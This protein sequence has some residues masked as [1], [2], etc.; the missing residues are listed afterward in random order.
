MKTNLNHIIALQNFIQSKFNKDVLYHKL[1]GVILPFVKEHH[2][3]LVAV[4]VP[5]LKNFSKYTKIPRKDQLVDIVI[6]PFY[7]EAAFALF[8]EKA[9]TG[10][11]TLM[12][13]LVWTREAF[14]QDDIEADLGL[15]IYDEK[16]ETR[17][18][19]TVYKS[20]SIQ[21][22]FG[23]FT[24]T[25]ASYYYYHQQSNGY[26]VG[27]PDSLKRVISQ[28][29]EKPKAAYLTGF[30]E[31]KD[32]TLLRYTTGEMDIHL[33]FPRILAYHKQG[34]IKFSAKGKPAVSTLNKMQ[35]TLKL[36]PFYPKETDKKLTVLRTRLIAGI[37]GVGSNLKIA[38]PVHETIKLYFSDYYLKRYESSQ[39]LLNHLSGVGYLD[40]YYTEDIEP[41]FIQILENLPIGKWVSIDNVEGYIMYNF[42][43][44]EIVSRNTAADKL[45]YSN[46]VGRYTEKD[47]IDD[48][49][50]D[51]AIVKPS[52]NGTMFL[53]GAFGLLDLMYYT[54]D[55]DFLGESA[56]SDYDD[57]KYV[58]LTPLG[59]YVVGRNK[60]YKPS[61][62]ASDSQI[63]LSKDSLTITT[64][65][66]NT[67]A[68]VILSPYAER[69]TPNRYR[70][71]Y[72][73]FLKNCS[74]KKELENKINL[75]KQTVCNKPPQNWLDFFTELNNKIN[76][77]K[78][79]T[80]ITTFQIP[81]ENQT[82]VKII[83]KDNKLKN[84][85]IKAEG[86]MVL[87]KKSNMPAFKKRLKEFGYLV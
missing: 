49:F 17:W 38:L 21:S 16:E 70:T 36:K 19:N 4:G 73:F 65:K 87:V 42:L 32:E 44:V 3:D 64:D 80:N 79:V 13:N 72:T 2:D 78:K 26:F 56:F 66:N 9:P 24:I 18:N 61:E 1:K 10:F 54:P 29:Y 34:N 40:D 52:I 58:R 59:A 5:R 43:P 67:T 84:L 60:D 74:T 11:M 31:I 6:M 22:E 55:L 68:S 33:E 86:Y 83:A 71:D 7:N 75:F 77:L 62:N 15:V 20:Y 63:E 30:E 47:Y 46:K 76:P 45:Y 35:R 27:L 8:R 41:T 28:Y 53:F 39:C 14:H 12:D 51:D 69:I 25:T 57:L 85:C 48:D 81:P 23:F 37:M 82:L 50:Y